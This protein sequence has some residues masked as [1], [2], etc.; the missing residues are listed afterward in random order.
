LDG[1]KASVLQSYSDH[2]ATLRPRDFS[3]LSCVLVALQDAGLRAG[4]AV[5]SRG[6]EGASQHRD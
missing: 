5:R 4:G 2:Q 3:K 1:W 6:A